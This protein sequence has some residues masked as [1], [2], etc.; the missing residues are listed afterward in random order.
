MKTFKTEQNAKSWLVSRS[1]LFDVT[2]RKNFA[3]EG[4]EPSFFNAVP[5]CKNKN[6]P[7]ER[8]TCVHTGTIGGFK[9]GSLGLFKIQENGR[10]IWL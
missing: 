9:I 5:P 4:S 2:F 8:Y 3:I 6:Y 7:P 10:Y 1:Q